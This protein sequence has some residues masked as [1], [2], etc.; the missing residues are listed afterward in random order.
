MS[1]VRIPLP[2]LIDALLG[3]ELRRAPVLRLPDDC[4]WRDLYVF[5]VLVR[6][7]PLAQ[8]VPRA[9]L[10]TPGCA[11]GCPTTMVQL[12]KQFGCDL[13]ASLI[14]M[15]A[16]AQQVVSVGTL[17]GHEKPRPH[18]IIANGKVVDGHC[19]ERIRGSRTAFRPWCLALTPR[20]L[21]ALELT[22]RTHHS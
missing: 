13:N 20:S 15:T 7:I 18:D 6:G 14:A 8:F 3:N 12:I 9:S 19:Y 1:R 22:E 21:T 2:A 11:R 4:L 5:Q 17:P 10:R 16:P